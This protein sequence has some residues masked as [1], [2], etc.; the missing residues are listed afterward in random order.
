MRCVT[1]SDQNLV[2]TEKP[3]PTPGAGDVLVRVEA[4]GIN[5]ADPMQRMG[6]YPAP[7]GWPQDVPGLEM[8]GVVV[9]VGPG[10][11]KSLIGQRVCA[12]VGGG[13]QAS[14]CVVPSE[15]LLFV[16]N[17]ASWSEAGGFA[18]TFT[19]AYDALVNQGRL[20]SGDRVLISGAAGG[21]GTAAIQIA[22]ALGATVIASTR[23]T[24][25]HQFLK[26][27]GADEVVT[28]NE[29]SSIQAVD[30]VVELVGAAHLQFALTV[31][32]PFA[33]VVIIGVGGGGAKVELNLL[34]LMST[35]AS[36]TGSTLRARSREEKAKIANDV[37]SALIPL[38]QS[39]VL[40]VPLAA[41]FTLD[42]V[43]AAYDYFSTPG[44]IGKVVLLTND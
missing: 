32:R 6:F 24:E 43:N 29:V 8:T 41:T 4:A 1:I 28:T 20:T 9:E 25:H 12:I 23:G 17:N 11:E 35:R 15:H 31:L 36:I 21:V 10:V 39:G 14:H 37:N 3:T 22:K 40:Q 27:L 33:R 26:Q 7:A 34:G 44:K 42:E 18:E 30:V 16:P 19:T 13:G 5:G 2:I 38:W